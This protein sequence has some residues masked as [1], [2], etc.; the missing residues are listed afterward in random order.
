MNAATVLLHESLIR[1]AKGALAAWE[2]W[3]QTRKQES[4]R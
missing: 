2:K 3:L 1:L 4:N